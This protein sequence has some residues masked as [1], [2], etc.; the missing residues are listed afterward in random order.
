MR[1]WVHLLYPQV[2][3]ILAHGIRQNMLMLMTHLTDGLYNGSKD[4]MTDHLRMDGQTDRPTN[5]L[6]N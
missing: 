6:T 4:K 1:T 2:L 5:Q 3:V